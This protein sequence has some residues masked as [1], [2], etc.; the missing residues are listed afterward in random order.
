MYGWGQLFFF[1]NTT[2]LISLKIVIGMGITLFFGGILNYLSLANQDT[3]RIIFLF[4]L[5]IFIIKIYNARSYL[6]FKRLF[7]NFKKINLIDTKYIFI[8]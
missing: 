1:K 5:V 7:E 6:K 3:I 8:N 2:Q 4:G